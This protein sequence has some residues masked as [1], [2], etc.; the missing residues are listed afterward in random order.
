M[1]E[2]EA[3]KIRRNQMSRFKSSKYANFLL[4]LDNFHTLFM[5]ILRSV[6]FNI[7]GQF[8]NNIIGILLY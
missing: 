6:R 8:H 1:Y 7:T 2:K 3:E 4:I 5:A